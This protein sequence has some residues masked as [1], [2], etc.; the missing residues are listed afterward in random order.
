METAAETYAGV[1]KPESVIAG[2]IVRTSLNVKSL[3]R[4]GG[5]SHRRHPTLL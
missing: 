4:G 5:D 2:G 1:G 3:G